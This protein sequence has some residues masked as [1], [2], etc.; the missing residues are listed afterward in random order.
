[1]RTAHAFAALSQSGDRYQLCLTTGDVSLQIGLSVKRSYWLKLTSFGISSSRSRLDMLGFP[2]VPNMS[3][4]RRGKP[5]RMQLEQVRFIG[6]VLRNPCVKCY[7]AFLK[8]VLN[9]NI[10]GKYALTVDRKDIKVC[11]GDE[12]SKSLNIAVQCLYGVFSKSS[13]LTCDSFR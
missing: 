8:N 4:M 13:L 1:M 6:F 7:V 11:F 12:K 3:A 9:S 2:V 10:N 5:Q